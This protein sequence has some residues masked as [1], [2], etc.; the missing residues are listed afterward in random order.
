MPKLTPSLKAYLA[1]F[2]FV[3]LLRLILFAIP[4]DY[5]L[6]EQEQMLSLPAILVI[7]AIGYAGLGLTPKAGF[8]EMMDKTVSHVQ[9]FAIPALLGLGF[10]ILSLLF[11]LVQPLG[12][13]I[14][15]KLPAS[16]LIYPIGG[17]LEEILFRL[18]LTTLLV[19]LISGVI[20]KGKGQT[21]V[22]WVVAVAVG[23]LYAFLQI[24]QYMSLTGEAVQPLVALRFLVLIGAYFIVA[25]YVFRKYGFLAAVTLRLA[26]Y[27]V[28]HILWGGLVLN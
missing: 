4:A 3:I 17:I 24:G 21:T 8:A 15:I 1:L 13:A 2:A 19:W 11:D 16:L 9:R 25:A 10:G 20:L 22:F 14:Q 27:L 26:D 6:Q 18:L 12:G 28:F 5:V 23:L 7:F